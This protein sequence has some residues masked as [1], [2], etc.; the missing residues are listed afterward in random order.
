MAFTKSSLPCFGQERSKFQCPLSTRVK[1]SKSSCV[2]ERKGRTESIS[3]AHSSL[4]GIQKLQSAT[5]ACLEV[6]QSVTSQTSTQVSRGSVTSLGN[7]P[8]PAESAMP[9]VDIWRAFWHERKASFS[10][11]LYVVEFIYI[12]PSC[13]IWGFFIQTLAY[14]FNMMHCLGGVY[15]QDQ[16]FGVSSWIVS[17]IQLCK[18]LR[19]QS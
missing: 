1:R 9:K 16:V 11:G 2:C 10:K 3:K 7:C 5:F 8:V 12:Q 18:N 17:S 6:S 14:C 4:G 13:F 15:L 19:Q